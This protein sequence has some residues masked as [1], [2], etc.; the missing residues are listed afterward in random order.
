LK[1]NKEAKRNIINGGVQKL[2]EIKLKA[3]GPIQQLISEIN[4]YF[5]DTIV[6]YYSPD[7]ASNLLNKLDN[8]S[9]LGELK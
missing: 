6:K 3:S 4:S 5:D 1:D 2:Q 8:Y 9:S 7:Y